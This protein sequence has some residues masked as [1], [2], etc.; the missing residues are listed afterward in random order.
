[1]VSFRFCPVV[2]WSLWCI[3]T[4]VKVGGAGGGG[5]PGCCGGGV[6]F[7]PPQEGKIVRKPKTATHRQDFARLIIEL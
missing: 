2:P 7:P 1:M 6:E 3:S 4:P 5:E